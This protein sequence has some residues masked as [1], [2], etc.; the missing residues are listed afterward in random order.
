MNDPVPNRIA[1]VSLRAEDVPTTAHFYRDVLGLRLAHHHAGRPH[2]D[3]GGTILVLLSGSPPP[4]AQE[5]FPQLAF[6]IDD[7][8][9]P[10]N[11]LTSHHV[12]LPWGVESDGH[13]RWAMFYDP[14]G[15]LVELVQFGQALHEDEAG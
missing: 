5:R 11:N 1:V 7:L 12:N 14:S 10:L 9:A 8:D 15:N 6:A 13:A 3:V 4:P 2:F